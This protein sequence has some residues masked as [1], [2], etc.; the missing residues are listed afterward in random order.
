MTFS[1]RRFDLPEMLRCGLDLRRD[2]K[3]AATMEEAARSLVRYFHESFVDE[4]GER[5]CA[6]VRFYKTHPYGGLGPELQSFA[7]GLMGGRGPWDEMKALVLLASAGQEPEWNDPRQSRGHR[8]IPLPS[9][10]IVEQAPMIA[11]LVREMGLDLD[12]VVAPRPE[13]I[14]GLEGKTY[15]I[16]YVADALG[17]PAIPAQDFVRSYGIRSVVGCGGIHMTGDLYAMILFSRV[18][19]PPECADRFRNVALDVKLAIS[20]FRDDAVFDA[21]A[22]VT[23]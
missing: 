18:P 19:I 12:D 1:L 11:Q 5:E 21:P 3:D 4:T 7:A 17:N 16:F 23:G 14:R 10:R 9:A 8:A 13:L 15:N 20:R 2:T 22:A 6:L